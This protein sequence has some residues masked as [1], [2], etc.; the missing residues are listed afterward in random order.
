MTSA[1]RRDIDFSPAEWLTAARRHLEA[2]QVYAAARRAGEI[3]TTES[4]HRA[5]R[6]DSGAWPRR[7][8]CDG[9]VAGG[10]TAVRI[11]PRDNRLTHRSLAG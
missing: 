11:A 5:S 9:G 2:T 3:G 1:A 4:T 6:P 10:S 7:C 8:R